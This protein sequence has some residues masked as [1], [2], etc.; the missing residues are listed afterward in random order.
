[1]LAEDAKSYQGWHFRQWLVDREENDPDDVDFVIRAIGA[2]SKNVH[3]WSYA[4]WYANRWNRLRDLHVIAS[5]STRIDCR[6]NSAWSA[7]RTAG[8]AIGVDSIAE[9]EYAAASLRKV[10]KNESAACFLLSLQEKEPTLTGRIRE[11]AQELVTLKP[12]N[13]VAWRML[14]STATE[15]EEIERICDELMKSDPNRIPFYTL[16]KT[17]VLKYE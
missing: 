9:F 12:E 8:M 4:I 11:L 14:L 17:G 2:D 6:N 3:A 1:V 13:P 15:R 5:E 16:V 10:G 7:R